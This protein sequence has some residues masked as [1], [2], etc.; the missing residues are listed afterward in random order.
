HSHAAHAI[1]RE[2]IRKGGGELFVEGLAQQTPGP[3][4]SGLHRCLRQL[5][6]IGGFLNAQFFNFTHD[7]DDAEYLRKIVDG[8]VNE[9]TNLS[10]SDG[11]LWVAIRGYQRERNNMRF[12]LTFAIERRQ[13]DRRSLPPQSPQRFIQRDPREPGGQAR[14]AA[15]VA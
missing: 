9:A 15:E 8:A 2:C 7:E 6:E 12:I 14:I 13:L 4:Q 10:L 1:E 5:E 11:A 3:V